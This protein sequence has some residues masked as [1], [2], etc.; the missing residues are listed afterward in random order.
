LLGFPTF[1]DYRL[2]DQ[3]AKTRQRRAGCS[4]RFGAGHAGRHRTRCLAALIAEEGGNFS[5]A[6]H[7]W[8]Y[9]AEKLRKAK[10]IWMKPRSHISSWTR[11]SR[12]L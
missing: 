2:D 4:T 7:D 8:R 10:L 12:R 9:Y 3:M 1:A 6:P 11:W 5:L